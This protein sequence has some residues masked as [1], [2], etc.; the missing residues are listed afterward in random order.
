MPAAVY[1]TDLATITVADVATGESGALGTV[2]WSEPTGSGAGGTAAQ[3]TD[4]FIVG[5]A[6]V[7]KSYNATGV[8]GLGA[9]TTSA[10][11][12]PT[13]GA[14]YV[15]T[16][17]SAPNALAT[18]ANGGMQ[19]IVGNTL[20][21]YRRYYVA[22][23]DTYTYGGFVCY[24][25]N[26]TVAASATQGTPNTTYQYF[27]MAT[28][29][30]N[31]IQRGNPFGIDAIRFGR[32]TLQ[33]VEGDL[34]NGYANFAA[35]AARNDLNTGGTIHR[36][37]I[38]QA[39][40]GVF[41]FQGHLLMGTASTI[42]DFRDSNRAITIQANEFVTS[43]FNLFEVRNAASRVDWTDI[44]ISSLSTV[45]R[46]N[47]LATNNATINFNG[48]TFNDMGTFTFQS[49]TSVIDTTFRRCQTITH[50]GA[51][52]T[53]SLIVGS[54]STTALTTANPS[55]ITDTEFVSAG[56]GH[57]ITITT[58][59]TY[60]LSGIIFTGYGTAGTTNAAIFNNSGGAVT[61]NIS[62]G[63][64]VPTIRNGTGATTNVVASANVTLT[65]LIADSEVRAYLGTN[66]A[67]ATELAGVESSGTSFNF[68]QSSGGQQG[69]IHI[70]HVNYQPVFLPITYSSTDV[71]IPIQQIVD[72]QY[73]RG[74]V[75][76]PS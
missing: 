40:N 5:T 27:G 3:E 69:Y 17:F 25:V 23:S 43:G 8:G 20:A 57:A 71:S 52:I 19:V 64:S 39:N 74:S 35:A 44:T 30:L 33:C 58:P 62:G 55:T 34:A 67:T 54:P 76:A 2:T 32:G 14:I 70:I 46:G 48:C 13:D 31:A 59:G 6:I 73:S 72:R 37:G 63:G 68:A 65:G 53:Q 61:L 26:P 51:S 11:T 60:T 24:P 75:F 12:I 7:A 56:T 18:K 47:F 41:Q 36:W 21:N 28:N 16:Y 15:W 50:G 29:V 42:V 22:G 4:Y 9:A 1:T 38:L 66:P 10:A 45:S 49:N